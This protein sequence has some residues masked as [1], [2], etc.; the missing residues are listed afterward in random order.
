L[1]RAIDTFALLRWINKKRFPWCKS[2]M[3][4]TRD[5]FLRKIGQSDNLSVIFQLTDRCVLSCRY[6]FAKGTLSHSVNGWLAQGVL[7]RA[8]QQS[9]GTRHK[10]VTFEWTGGEPFLS[11]IE[12]FRTVKMLQDKYANK[13]FHNVVQTSGYLLDKELIDYLVEHEF[14]ISVTID[15]TRDVHNFNRPA[16]SGKP[17]FAKIL[18]TRKYIV[19]KQGFCG[20]I[21]TVTKKNIGK[22][23]EILELFRSLGV[24]AFHSN[25]YVYFAK[26]R[27][28]DRKAAISNEDFARYFI[29]Q[30][31]AWYAKADTY[32]TP[33]T[34]EHILKSILRNAGVRNT[35]CTY[36]GRCLTNYIAV[37]PNGDAY[38]CPKFAGLSE[39][40]LGNVNREPIGEILSIE[41]PKM[42]ALIRE[43][44]AA[45][46]DCE[47]D[48][49]K[50][51]HVCNGGCPYLS[52]I[53]S[54]GRNIRE[55]D[56]LCKG[57]TMLYDYMRG[58]VDILKSET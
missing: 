37:M 54:G 4:T 48:G 35:I 30:F 34:I 39:M 27:V 47:R 31:N 18:D 57:K 33:I 52:L 2:Q 50:Y 58:V 11:G 53:K 51:L 40:R 46:N 24:N 3:T 49:C 55:R 19:G 14:R 43:R 12:L 44:V 42:K 8:V 16:S 7:E 13:T 41:A 21:S 29:N 17:S 20:F 25:P 38:L 22:E 28:K 9:F 56:R 6:C 36:G 26:N 23:A 5:D 45:I 32:P 1:K 15:G 10:S